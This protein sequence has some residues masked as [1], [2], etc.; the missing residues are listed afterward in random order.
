VVGLA[1]T[2]EGL[3]RVLTVPNALSVLRLGLVAWC[4][5]SLFASH[6]RVLAA[7]L[8]AI[9]G[10]TDFLDGWV[11]R[12]FH[13]VTTLGKVLDPTVDRI[14]TGSAVIGVVVYGAVPVWL[15]VVV[16]GRELLVSGM[17]IALALLGASRIDVLFI[18]KVAAFG[19]M[20]ALPLFL[21]GDGH[22]P[23]AFFYLVLAW[24]FAV[25]SLAA[26]LAS[27]AAYVPLARRALAAGRLP[28]IDAGTP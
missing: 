4:L 8:L 9:A 24:V 2:E 1:D 13:Q 19:F 12:R 17:G 3:D 15:A 18:G 27:A 14:V 23:Y 11:A 25:P 7:V 20:C 10:T 22:G 16:L 26:S 6:Q 5:T 21:L 28:A